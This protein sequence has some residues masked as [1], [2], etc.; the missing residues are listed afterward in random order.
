ME[1]ASSIPLVRSYSAPV[2][3]RSPSPHRSV[4]SKVSPRR[5]VESNAARSLKGKSMNKNWDGCLERK[6]FLKEGKKSVS[7][8]IQA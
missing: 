4:E 1:A 5:V 2:P 6:V 3:A 8:A 7:L